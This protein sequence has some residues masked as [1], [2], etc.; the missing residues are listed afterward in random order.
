MVNEEDY[1]PEE[2]NEENTVLFSIFSVLGTDTSEMLKDSI[3][4]LTVAFQG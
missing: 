2:G 4:Y 1:V 3:V